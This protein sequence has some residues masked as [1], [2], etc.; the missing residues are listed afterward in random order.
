VGDGP[1]GC[2]IRRYEDRTGHK[3]SARIAGMAECT[4]KLL[5]SY[6]VA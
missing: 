4:P 3:R 1:I 2:E 5:A 6:D